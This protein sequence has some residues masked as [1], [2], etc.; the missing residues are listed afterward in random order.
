MSDPT[1]LTFFGWIPEVMLA[2]VLEIMSSSLNIR[3]Y[4]PQTLVLCLM[5]YEQ[6]LRKPTN[7]K[8]EQRER[9]KLVLPKSSRLRKRKSRRLLGNQG[10]ISNSGTFWIPNLLRFSWG[11]T[12]SKRV[13]DTATTL[14]PPTS[15]S[16]PKVSTPP[17][18]YTPD[19]NFFHMPTPPHSPTTTSSPITTTIPITI[20]PLPNIYVGVSQTHIYVALSTPFYTDSTSTT[21][22]IVS[23]LMSTVNV[24]DAGVGVTFGTTFG[25]RTY[26]ASPL[27]DDYLDVMYG[28]D[29]DDFHNFVFSPFTVQ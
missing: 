16:I 12:C 26:T 3:S 14:K 24:S 27:K 4:L 22:S 13:E 15:T 11:W 20:A 25:P 6:R 9:V 17:T 23:T 29:Q 1:K 21:T 8:G 19:S 10:H 5:I 18:T 28:D 7:R 2:K